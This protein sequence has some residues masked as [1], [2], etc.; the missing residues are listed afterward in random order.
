MAPKKHIPRVYRGAQ[1]PK[2]PRSGSTTPSTNKPPVPAKGDVNLGTRSSAQAPK[3]WA[4]T[5]AQPTTSTT[6][7]SP[8]KP[9]ESLGRIRGAATD[10]EKGPATL[11]GNHASGTT[12]LQ[13]TQ[14]PAMPTPGLLSKLATALKI[15]GAASLAGIA[16]SDTNRDAQQRAVDAEAKRRGFRNAR[17]MERA[18]NLAEQQ[19]KIGPVGPDMQVKEG[20][21]LYSSVPNRPVGTKGTLSGKAVMW[22]GYKWLADPSA[23]PKNGDTTIKEGNSFTFKDGL[24]LRSPAIGA[25]VHAKPS[26]FGSATRV[27]NGVI[28]GGGGGSVYAPQVGQAPKPNTPQPSSYRDEGKGLYKGSE[29][30]VKATGGNY[31]PLMQRMF[32][33][34]TGQGPGQQPTDSA[35]SPQE[36]PSAPGTPPKSNSNY[37]TPDQRSEFVA[38]DGRPYKGPAF[39]NPTPKQSPQYDG[40]DEPGKLGQAENPLKVLDQLLKR[41]KLSISV[42]N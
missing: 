18:Y 42:S 26:A 15:G 32:G 24:W 16:G 2:A 39:G 31:N 5:K 19:K 4:P 36:Q 30:Y 9:S 33:Y 13:A 22:D 27:N 38:P 3:G 14:G 11:K 40:N 25:P 23:P 1:S 35:P 21:N 34:Q 41:K 12:R 7:A 29:E 28:S 8:P 10:L 20:S 6:S 17:E 37:N